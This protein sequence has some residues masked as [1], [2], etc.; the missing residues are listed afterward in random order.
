[1]RAEVQASNVW[2]PAPNQKPKERYENA[3]HGDSQ[4]KQ[5]LG[6]GRYAEAEATFRRAILIQEKLGSDVRRDFAATLHN[7]ALAVSRQGRHAEA[8]DFV[9]RALAL[10]EHDLPNT[11]SGLLGMMFHKA[12]LLRRA[13]R[14]GEA[15]K[16]ERVARQAKAERGDEDPNRWLVDFREFAR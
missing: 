2:K 1:M 3:I 4:G 9:S 14:K 13:H 15:A 6:G 7:M 5:R 11:D 8:L 12:E 10:R 16:L